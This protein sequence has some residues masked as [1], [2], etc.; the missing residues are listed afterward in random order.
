MDY[1]MPL[2]DGI[3]TTERIIE[4]MKKRGLDVL[5]LNESPYICCLSAYTDQA[6]IDK[7]LQAGMHDYMTK[8]A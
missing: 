7:A 6:Y 1:S 4:Y 2:I 8:P 3:E 5:N